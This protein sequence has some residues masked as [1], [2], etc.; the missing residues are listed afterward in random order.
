MKVVITPRG[1]ANYGLDD[2]KRM[3]AKGIEVDF[4]QTGK[5]Y[6]PEVFLEKCKDA[7]GIIVGVDQID[8]S[9]IEQCPNVKVIC[10]FGV[11]TD[12]IDLQ[13]A[14]D[15]AILVGRT[16]GSNSIAV[17]EHV[18][19]L[20]FLAS[21]NLFSTIQDSKQGKWDKPTG[22]EL[23]KKTLGIVGFGAIGRYLAEF[24][25]GLDMNILIYDTIDIPEDI[26][27]QYNVQSVSF[28][29]IIEKS[30][31]IS[32]HVPLLDSTKNLIG[33][34]E[35]ER[36]KSNAC[37]INTARGGIVDEDALYHALKEHKIGSACFDVFSVE[38][39]PVDSP[40]VA[41]P[42]FYLTPHI[43]ARTSESETRTCHMSTD[44]VLE[45]LCP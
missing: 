36:M 4:N 2:V 6:S 39:P 13:A 15:H 11:G 30:D 43:A 38:P 37:L 5:A 9:F 22:C 17:A 44:I 29:T 24:V 23:H 12:N 32:L 45:K 26:L 16:V 7:D 42:N 8:R 14:Q 18:V 10:K 28:D 25:K 31:Y 3:E 21:K 20:M 1:F 35:L 19:S 40:L 34:K 27:Q 41:L 33:E